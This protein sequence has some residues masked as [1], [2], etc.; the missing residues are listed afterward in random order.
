MILPKLGNIS[1]I[2]FSAVT[3][4]R[5]P[6]SRQWRRRL[7]FY[8]FSPP[9]RG[10]GGA[11]A[12]WAPCKRRKLTCP[13]GCHLS[14][15]VSDRVAGMAAAQVRAGLLAAVSPSKSHQSTSPALSVPDA[16]PPAS[17]PL[18]S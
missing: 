7:L 9:E 15:L 6:A 11:E 17:Q 12:A 18:A 10:G 1:F 13:H 16:A 14:A 3:F 5:L 4:T 2:Y 8:F